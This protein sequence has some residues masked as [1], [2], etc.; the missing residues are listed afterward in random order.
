MRIIQI[1]DHEQMRAQEQGHRL[2]GSST[3]RSNVPSS[4]ARDVAVFFRAALREALSVL[5]FLEEV[6]VSLW[7]EGCLL[8]ERFPSEG[9]WSSSPSPSNSKSAAAALDSFCL[10]P[11]KRVLHRQLI[12]QR[13]QRAIV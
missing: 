5:G 10:F 7:P 3:S 1:S 6:L 12:S 13:Y 8:P 2:F 11:A 4:G 9:G